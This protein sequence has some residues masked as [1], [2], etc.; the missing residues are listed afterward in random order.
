MGRIGHF[1]NLESSKIGNL[2]KGPIPQK[3][4]RYSANMKAAFAYI[5]RPSYEVSLTE[6]GLKLGMKK[7]KFKTP[8]VINFRPGQ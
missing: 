1:L 5:A 8:F 3:P 7:A 4:G 6:P 2:C